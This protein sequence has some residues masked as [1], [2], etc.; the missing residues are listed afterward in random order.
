M[1]LTPVTDIHLREEA[2]LSPA[3]VERVMKDIKDHGWDEAGAIFVDEERNVIG[4]EHHFAAAVKLKMTQV[5]VIFVT[6]AEI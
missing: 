5:P 6:R 1:E 2:W 4:G 3:L